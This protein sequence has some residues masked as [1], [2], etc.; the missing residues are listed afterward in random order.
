MRKQ[1]D[2]TISKVPKAMNWA[3]LIKEYW[4]TPTNLH[5]ILLIAFG[6]MELH[7]KQLPIAGE[8][9]YILMVASFLLDRANIFEAQQTTSGR[10]MAV[11][12]IVGYALMRVCEVA[13]RLTPAQVSIPACVNGVLLIFKGRWIYEGLLQRQ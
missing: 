13:E 1:L 2:R 5:E 8:R 9:P 7:Q 10:V 6:F 3:A 11:A 12:R 4:L